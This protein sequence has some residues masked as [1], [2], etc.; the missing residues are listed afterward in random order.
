MAKLVRNVIKESSPG[1]GTFRARMDF[2][3]LRELHELDGSNEPVVIESCTVSIS[4]A[5]PTVTSPATLET[6]YAVST[7]ISGNAIS[8]DTYSVTFTATLSTG[9]TL[10]PRV[11]DWIVA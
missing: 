1:A 9:Q 8:G 4:P 2:G 5:G 11:G 6:D 3:D 10:P 7:V